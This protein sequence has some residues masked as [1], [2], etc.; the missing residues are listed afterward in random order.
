M[1]SKK[2]FRLHCT[3]EYLN[4]HPGGDGLPAWTTADRPL[5]NTDL[6]LW[7]TFTAH[8]V[9]RPLS[10]AVV[11]H[12]VGA[13]ELRPPVHLRRALTIQARESNQT[14]F[15]LMCAASISRSRPSARAAA[16]GSIWLSTSPVHAK[17]RTQSRA[18]AT[19][20]P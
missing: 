2:K 7:H 18:A 8:H 9:V 13:H 19:S 16:A 1:P 6:V 20:G 4:Q 11:R 3:G 12:H 10:Q 15:P 14:P 5:E 17:P